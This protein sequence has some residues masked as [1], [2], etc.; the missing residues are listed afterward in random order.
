MAK[1]ERAYSSEFVKYQKFII[2]NPAYVGMPMPAVKKGDGIPWVAAKTG[3]LGKARELWWDKKGLELKKKGLLVGNPKISDI[4]RFI[5]PTKYKACQTCGKSLSIEYVYL[6]ASGIK[7]IKK[8]FPD[9]IFDEFTE[10]GHLIGDICKQH[11]RDGLKHFVDTFKLDTIKLTQREVETAFKEKHISFLSPG[12]MSNAP[13]R[14]DGFHSYNKCCRSQ[15]DKGRSKENLSRYGEDRRAYEN[16]ADGD[17]KAASW[18][19]KEFAKHNVSAD[20]IGPISLGFCHTPFFSPMTKQ[21]NSAKNNRIR[22]SDVEKLLEAEACG[23]QIISWHTKL[24]WDRLKDQIKN[25]AEAVE[26]SKILRKHLHR[27]LLVLNE[28]KERGQNTFL[29]SLLNPDYAFYS[30]KIL[31]FDPLTGGYK[32]IEKTRGTRTEYSRNAERYIKIAFESLEQYKLKDNRKLADIDEEEL[33][34]LVDKIEG[35]IAKFGNGKAKL[36]LQKGLGELRL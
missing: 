21:E 15:Q 13:D 8:N 16:W 36:T 1:L 26:L 11:G 33:R 18:L 28:L 31:G 24:V 12:V 22:F 35:T 34:K 17:W 29:K 10:I 19:M 9:M 27:V 6:N 14:L 4:A 23:H 3:A 5:H 2:A 25:D 32:K 20:H 7:K 30:I